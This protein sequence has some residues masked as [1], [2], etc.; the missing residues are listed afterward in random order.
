MAALAAHAGCRATLYVRLVLCLAMRTAS[1]AW[2]VPASCG[3]A[4]STRRLSS[5]SV[6]A[7]YPVFGDENSE[8]CLELSCL[9]WLRLQHMQ[10]VEPSCLRTRVFLPC[11]WAMRTSSP[12][13]RVPAS[14][15]CACSTRRLSSHPVCAHQSFCLVFGDEN[16]KPCSELSCLLW[17]RLQHTQAVEPSWVSSVQWRF[18]QTK[19]LQGM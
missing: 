10:A 12:A 14:C 18:Q 19:V 15:G 2:R 9:L 17:L 6:C 11:I 7:S 5:H 1:P 16:S 3:C 4:C 8:P 13:R